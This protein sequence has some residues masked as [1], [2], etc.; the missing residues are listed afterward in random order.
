MLIRPRTWRRAAVLA[1]GAT[2]LL[3]GPASAHPY[4]HGGEIPV[5]SLAEITLDLA[6]GCD[7]EAEGE[8]QPTT[9]VA[10]EVPDWLRVVEADEPEGWTLEVEEDDDLRIVEVAWL[11]DGGAEPA[12]T[13]DLEVVASGEVGE[14]RYL[15]V[16]Q[17]CDDI[18]YR[19]IG[20]PDEPADDPGVSV[21]LVEADPDAPPPPEPEPEPDDDGAEE[22]EASDDAAD[23]EADEAAEDDALEDDAVEEDVAD[24]DLAADEPDEDEQVDAAAEGDDGGGMAWVWIVLAAVVLAGAGYLVQRRSVGGDGGA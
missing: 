24:E 14:E 19:W 15:G 23:D 20:T 8:G 11:D 10:V 1:A 7:T 4:I 12:P 13:F 16:F 3:A 6:H 17:A 5:D 21:T 9:E 2:L 22:D 18:T